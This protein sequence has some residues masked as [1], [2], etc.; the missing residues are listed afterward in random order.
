MNTLDTFINTLPPAES[1]AMYSWLGAT[2][3]KW[4]TRYDAAAS[5]VKRAMPHHEALAAF[6]STPRLN[7]ELLADADSWAGRQVA[8]Q[9]GLG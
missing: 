7:E 4:Q 5:L 2:E 9:V 8:S 1:D 6:H 3:Q